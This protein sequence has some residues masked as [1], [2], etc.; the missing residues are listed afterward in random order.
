MLSK[1]AQSL[2]DSVENTANSSATGEQ[3]ED[4][5]D[6]EMDADSI[7]RTRDSYSEEAKL[8]DFSDSPV[9]HDLEQIVAEKLV[10]S[11]QQPPADPNDLFDL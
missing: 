3:H 6:Q 9:D 5:P 4:I 8:D 1:Y 2:V 11:Q 7:N 10:R